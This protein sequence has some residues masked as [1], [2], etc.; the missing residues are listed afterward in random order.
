[1]KHVQFNVADTLWV[2]LRF[3]TGTWESIFVGVTWMRKLHILDVKLKLMH[4]PVQYVFD[5]SYAAFGTF[6]LWTGVGGLEDLVWS[7]SWLHKDSYTS[8]LKFFLL[9]LDPRSLFWT[10]NL[11]QAPWMAVPK[12]RILGR[13]GKLIMIMI[14]TN[15]FALKFISSF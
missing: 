10:W 11:S 9:S 2:G 12:G 15:V 13:A 5:V 1:M 8:G 6:K 4:T 14:Y 3:R 7:D